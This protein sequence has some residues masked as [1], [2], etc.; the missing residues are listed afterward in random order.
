MT[1]SSNSIR[2]LHLWGNYF[3]DLFD[4]SHR[5]CLSA[6]WPS[7]VVARG[8][9]E[10]EGARSELPGVIGFRHRSK[11]EVNSTALSSRIQRVLLRKVDEIGFGRLTQRTVSRFRPDVIHCHYGTTGA[12]LVK[13]NYW[14]E[15]PTVVSFYG[16][17]ASASMRDPATVQRYVEMGRGGAIAHVLC[18]AVA[19]RL[20]GIGWPINHIEVGNLPAQVE[21]APDLGTRIG[22]G[23]RLLIPARFVEKKGHLVLLDAVRLAVEHV[24]DI[25]LTCFGYG[26]PEWLERA[27]VRLQLKGRVRVVDNRQTSG[28]FDDYMNLLRE[29]DIVVMPSMVSS[30]GD[31]EGGPALSVVM[32][33]AAG[34]PVVVSDFPGAER[35]VT[36]RIEGRVLPAGNVTALATVLVEMSQSRADWSL[37]GAAG[38]ARVR[39]EFSDSAY[40]H[41]LQRAYARAMGR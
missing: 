25:T 34:K 6:N 11:A 1:A 24:P 32:A 40:W 21:F 5:L 26:S 30:S 2:V 28:F 27:I 36:D 33:Q 15:L 9:F 4:H 18:S 38:R 41:F 3:P 10:G 31:D 29:H 35:S 23:T 7:E 12:E 14:P 22:S 37:M 20:V 16:V 19:D 17:D 13:W 8:L 39:Q